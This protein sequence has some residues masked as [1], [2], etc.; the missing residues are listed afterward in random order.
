MT[1]NNILPE[2][3]QEEVAHVEALL[4]EPEE[5]LTP[6]E[7][8]AVREAVEALKSWQQTAQLTAVARGIRA[9]YEE[10]LKEMRKT[11]S[12]NMFKFGYAEALKDIHYSIQILIAE[13]QVNYDWQQS[14]GPGE[15]SDGSSPDARSTS[16][17][18]GPEESETPSEDVTSGS[19][20]D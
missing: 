10:V 4:A 3:L 2:E 1:E 14:T 15:L 11:N 16:D 19:T 17:G 5:A 6:T 9:K 13:E 20:E 12:K 7:E 18:T 8:D